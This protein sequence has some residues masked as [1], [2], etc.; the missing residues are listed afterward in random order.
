M[1]PLSNFLQ[2][3]QLACRSLFGTPALLPG[4]LWEE[5]GTGY[6]RG[7]GGRGGGREP[8]MGECKLWFKGAPSLSCKFFSKALQPQSR[9]GWAHFVP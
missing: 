2:W 8:I 4:G 5:G 3:G 9:L 1:P 6:G 7:W